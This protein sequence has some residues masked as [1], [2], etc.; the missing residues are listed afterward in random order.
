MIR[1]ISEGVGNSSTGNITLTPT[2]A[3]TVT[4]GTPEPPRTEDEKEKQGSFAIFFVLSVLG[5][6]NSSFVVSISV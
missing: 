2:A 4:V 3:R 5:K 1:G 6:S